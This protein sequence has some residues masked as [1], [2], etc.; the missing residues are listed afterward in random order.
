MNKLVLAIIVVAIVAAAA[1]AVYLYYNPLGKTGS[2]AS[3]KAPAI[4][5]VYADNAQKDAGKTF[6]GVFSLLAKNSGI[7]LGN[8]TTCML[9]ASSLPVKLRFYP[10]LLLKGNFSEK[11][12]NHTV[13]DIEGAKLLDPVIT[14]SIIRYLKIQPVYSYH[15]KLIV[16]KAENPLGKIR[17]NESV[18]KDSFS[19]IA[20]ASIDQIQYVSRSQA[21]VKLDIAPYVIFESKEELDKNVHYL[22]KAGKDYYVIKKD[23]LA[24]VANNVLGARGLDLYGV[25]PPRGDFPSIGS[26]NAPV[27]LYIF[28]DFWCPYCALFYNNTFDIV[29]QYTSSGKLVV[30]A[31]DFLIHENAA[32]I[33]SL[34]LCLY[35]LTGNGTMYFDIVNEIYH[36]YAKNLTR[37]LMLEDVEGIVA[38]YVDNNTLSEA[39]NCAK[40]VST[41]H[42]FDTRKEYFEKYL[43]HGTPGFLVVPSGDKPLVSTSGYLKPEEFRELIE[44][45]LR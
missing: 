17:A 44:W 24:S 38:K 22:E 10:A 1:A 45:A 37:P 42:Y 20:M 39:K 33:H 28:E 18:I 4:I 21:P 34:L 43:I 15:A 41:K 16:V 32:E 19:A 13:A 5:Y 23:F 3:C 7:Q 6:V 25:E 9:P 29:K 27:K 36:Q 26:S 30:Y 31:V 40:N 35:R 2:I 8:Y 12:M 11:I 14:M